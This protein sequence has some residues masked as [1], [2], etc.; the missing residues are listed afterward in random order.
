MITAEEFVFEIDNKEEQKN[1]KLG[2]VAELF[3][4]K[5]A[6]VQFDGEDIPSEKQYAYLESYKPTKDDRVLLASL[7][8]TYVVLGKVNYNVSPPEEVEVDR[9]IFDLKT[10]SMLKGMQVSGAATFNNGMTVTGN[11]G[12]NGTVTA[13]GLSSSGNITASGSLSGA[14]INTSGSLGAGDTTLS[15]LDVSGATTLNGLNVNGSLYANKTLYA[16]SGFIHK[17]GLSFFGQGSSNAKITVGKLTGT[18]EI[19]AIY[20][21]LNVLIGALQ[22]Y[23]LIA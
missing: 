3:D 8:G 12:V 23:G 2:V 16:Q 21:K 18:A 14:S 10:V 17:G 13:I 20:N 15:S 1:F 11:V 4:N 6:K 7:G 19:N 22:S 9:Y 5:T